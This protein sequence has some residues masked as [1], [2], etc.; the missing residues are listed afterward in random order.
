[1]DTTDEVADDDLISTGEAAQL[2]GVH[3]TTVARYIAEGRLPAKR[4]PGGQF[5]IRRDEVLKLLREV[6]DEFGDG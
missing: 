3:R 6:E 4:L 1:M 5:R 2:L